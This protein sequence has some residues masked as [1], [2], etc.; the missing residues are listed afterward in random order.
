[1]SAPKRQTQREPR[2]TVNEYLR[3]ER[4]AEGRSYYLDGMVYAM[5]GESDDH[6]DIS[7]NLAL[8]LGSQ[9]KG[10]DCRGRTKDTKVRSGPF[11]SAG[12]TTR[13]LFSYPDLVV[14]CGAVEHHDD[15]TDV[16]LNPSVIVEVLSPSTEAFDRGEKFNRYQ[17]WNPT[18]RDYLL[19]SQD[20]VQ[21]EHYTRQTDGT[22]TYQRYLGLEA[23][24]TI[25]SI[26]CTLK[27]ADVYDRVGFAGAEADMP[28]IR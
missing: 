16:I 10:K 11:L 19:V 20:Q 24:A 26:G 23:S 12:E 21:I 27:L 22:W 17:T 7:M 3:L 28:V 18:L 13:G 2:C 9:L 15:H 8:M 6:G 4:A 14:I 5:A 1:M 25:A